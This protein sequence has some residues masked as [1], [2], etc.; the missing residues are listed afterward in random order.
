M[1]EQTKNLKKDFNILFNI[2]IN[3]GLCTR[4]GICAGVCPT[5]AITFDENAFPQLSGNCTKCGFCNRCCPGKDVNFPE[6]SHRIFNTDYIPDNPRGFVQNIYV[7]HPT[8]KKIRRAGTSGGLVTGLLIYLLQKKEIDGAIVVAMDSHKGYLTQGI[9]ATTSEEILDAAQS[10]YCITPSMNVL[11]TIR[12][13][14]GRFAVVALPCQL[15]GLRKLELVDPSLA[16]KI[17][18]YFGLFCHCNLDVNSH[19]DAIKVC[20][21]D[22]DEVKKFQFRGNGWPGGFHVQKKDGSE[23]SLHKINA[24]NVMNVMFRIYGSKRCYLCYDALA[25]YA[26]LSFGDFWAFD[27]TGEWSKRERCTLV[28][29]RTK[30]GKILLEEAMANGAIHMNTLPPERDSRRILQMATGKKNN[31]IARL[32]ERKKKGYSNP[33]YFFPLPE[34]TRQTKRSIKLYNLFQLLRGPLR[35]KMVL[36]IL[37]SPIGAFLDRLNIIRKNTFHNYHNN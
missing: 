18:Y 11:Q 10:K 27:Y 19:L 24:K 17:C 6:L 3:R 32:Y 9:L 5:K 2:V 16:N 13:Q 12:K 14:K 28:Y 23:I 37:F 26:D 4:C 35:R 29:Q 15:H 1:T 21:I 20:N 34:P 30:R 8:Q 22:L 33:N 36:W 25:E 31:T 7:G